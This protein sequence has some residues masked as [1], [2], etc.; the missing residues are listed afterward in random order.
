VRSGAAPATAGFRQLCVIAHHVFDQ[1]QDAPISDVLDEV[2][3]ACA[4]ARLDYDGAPIREAVE[5]VQ[6]ARRRG[7]RTPRQPRARAC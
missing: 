4:R 2:K 7:Y 5:A 3:W 1:H 6:Q